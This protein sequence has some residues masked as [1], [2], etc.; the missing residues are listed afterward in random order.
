V[1]LG[2]LLIKHE[3]L[4]T[5]PYLDCCGREWRKC[6]CAKKGKLT[7]GVG[8][9]LDDGG[10]SRQ[11]ALLLRDNDIES[12]RREATQ[13][14]PWFVQLSTVRQEVVLNMLFNLGLPRFAAFGRMIAAI[15]Q[16]DFNQAASQMLASKWASQVG[17]RAAELAE[18]MRSD[19][20]PDSSVG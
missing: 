3:N 10:I 19:R 15:Q 20:Y 5:K 11:E 14:F 17:R 2:D 13:A 4:R 8:R 1:S 16:G 12:A 18:M 9:N 7:I 6:E